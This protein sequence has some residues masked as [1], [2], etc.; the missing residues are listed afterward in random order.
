[1]QQEKILI[2]EDESRVAQAFSRALSM[3]EGGGYF[4]E[5]YESGEEALTRLRKSHFDLLITD[6][7][8]AGMSG[9]ELLGECRTIS[10][11]TGSILITAYGS[12]E[13]EQS[14]NQL[15]VD[16]YL[17]KPFSMQK[18]VQTVQHT[19]KRKSRAASSE[20]LET[21]S[22]KE[23]R[24]IQRCMDALRED[25]SAHAVLLLDHAGQ[26]LAESG[27]K[28]EFDVGAFL[29]LL[30]NA[31]TA[32]NAVSNVLGNP[33]A[34]DLHFH[35]G[36]QYETYTAR[37]T[38]QLFLSV[39]LD[40]RNKNSRIGMVRLYLSRAI[41]DLRIRLTHMDTAVVEE[42]LGTKPKDALPSADPSAAPEPRS[43][44]AL[45]DRHTV[46]NYEQAK[47]LG[48]LDLDRV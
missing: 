1:M 20:K 7:R 34:L 29:A 6:L 21:Q 19:L 10:P 14:A 22:E 46:L 45:D 44:L 23:M 31:M 16:A 28:C 18:L 8:M 9:L 2:A 43:E 27:Q 40:K 37:V 36:K 47:S 39:V 11:T 30:G 4:V 24:A 25:V 35:E 41:T 42:T 17:A 38:D 26:L 15:A 5:T 13:V 3:P 33:G 12:P 48:L 32:T